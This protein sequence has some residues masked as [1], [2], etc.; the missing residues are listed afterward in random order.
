MQ[1]LCAPCC[2]G[3]R[4]TLRGPC[5][6]SCCCPAALKRKLG[7]IMRESDGSGDEGGQG[8][9]GSG[10]GATRLWSSDHLARISTLLNAASSEEDAQ[11][12]S[13]VVWVTD[14]KGWCAGCEADGYCIARWPCRILSTRGALARVVPFGRE[15]W[16]HGVLAAPHCPRYYS[17]C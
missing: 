9:R 3:G 1:G 7:D 11:A 10:S 6:L 8:G 15:V 14:A 2:D 5:V 13:D 12:T 16:W 17:C 4:S